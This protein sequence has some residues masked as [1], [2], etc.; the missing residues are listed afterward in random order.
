M[1]RGSN[2]DGEMKVR[3]LDYDSFT[4]IQNFLQNSQVVIYLLVNPRSGSQEG[5]VFT[6]LEKQASFELSDGEIW[7]LN[8]VN[9]LEDN[10]MEEFK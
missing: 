7:E 5:K 2:F 1:E 6:D 3:L 10:S 4:Q 9:I 8:I